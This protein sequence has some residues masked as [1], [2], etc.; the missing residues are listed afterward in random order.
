[1]PCNS[2]PYSA[3]SHQIY[4]INAGRPATGVVCMHSLSKDIHLHLPCP[5]YEDRQQEDVSE[6]ED[7]IIAGA[8]MSLR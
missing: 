8:E 3:Y 6:G 5:S 1:M 2:S 7:D 4:F